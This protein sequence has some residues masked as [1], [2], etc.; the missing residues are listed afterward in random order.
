MEVTGI[1]WSR[2][3]IPGFYDGINGAA[4]PS[5]L[6]LGHVSSKWGVLVLLSLSG[7]PQRWGELKRSIEG[8]SE[9]MLAQTLRTLEEDGLLEREAFPVIPP[10]V[11]YRLTPL[12]AEL[13]QLLLPVMSWIV[14]KASDIVAGSTEEELLATS[15]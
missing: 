10:K 8:V 12:G 7:G 14:D 13:T 1:D 5:R 15:A 9:K 2:E 6:L 4:C 11:E 3:Q